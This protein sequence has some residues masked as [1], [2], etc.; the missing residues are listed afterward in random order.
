MRAITHDWH[1]TEQHASPRQSLWVIPSFSLSAVW[2][3]PM[4]QQPAIRVP[5]GDAPVAE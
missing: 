5:M 4:Q 1:T 2:L 3:G